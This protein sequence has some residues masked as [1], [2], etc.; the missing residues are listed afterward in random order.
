MDIIVH[1]RIN[2]R[3]TISY[4]YKKMRINKRETISYK[5]KKKKEIEILQS[6][7]E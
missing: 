7:L 5:H 6:I 2:K 3:E 4:K 1:L